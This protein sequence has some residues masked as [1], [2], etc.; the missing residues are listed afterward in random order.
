TTANADPDGDSVDNANEFD[1][2]TAPLDRD[3]DNDGRRDGREDRD[4]DG[5]NNAA[6]D[7]TAN[8][9][10]D[11][12]T[13]GDGIPDGKEQAGVVSAYDEDTGELT[14]DLSNGSSVTAALT[15]RT[16]VQCSTEEQ[17]EEEQEES[18]VDETS[19]ED[20]QLAG[21]SHNRGPES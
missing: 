19:T 12:D 7:L 5:L 13:D 1:E 8:D 21:A 2:G 9:P 17:A 16:R 11:R 15:D 10:T 6:E 20:D 4:R 18:P 3:S 14:I